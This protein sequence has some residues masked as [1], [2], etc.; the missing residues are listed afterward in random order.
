MSHIICIWFLLVYWRKLVLYS[1]INLKVQWPVII[2]LLN[3]AEVYLKKTVFPMIWKYHK[4]THSFS[5]DFSDH[6]LL[7]Q[8][9]KHNEQ[10]FLFIKK[11]V[12]SNLNILVNFHITVHFPLFSHFSLF[13][14]SFN[15]LC[16]F[17]DIHI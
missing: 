15:Y 12:F 6:F 13:H 17:D 9:V 4:T 14:I 7:P 1:I 2:F 5:I 3:A 11:E 10:I 16:L 8:S